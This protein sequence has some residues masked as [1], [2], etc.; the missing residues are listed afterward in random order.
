VLK[1][2]PKFQLKQDK[3]VKILFIIKN[4]RLSL[5]FYKKKRRPGIC[6]VE[7]CFIV[8]GRGASRRPMLRHF[9]P[10]TYQQ[11]KAEREGEGEGEGGSLAMITW[12]EKWEGNGERGGR[13]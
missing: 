10:L 3:S 7:A 6:L 1:L 9:F 4:V 12:R 5:V 8:G 11:K 2:T 13:Q